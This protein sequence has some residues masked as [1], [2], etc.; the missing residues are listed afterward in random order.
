MFVE[1]HRGFQ[2]MIAWVRFGKFLRGDRAVKYT[3][4]GGG[5]V[6]WPFVCCQV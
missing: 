3:M 4:M 1:K 5:G 6:K 2:F